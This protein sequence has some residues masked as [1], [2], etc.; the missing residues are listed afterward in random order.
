LSGVEGVVVHAKIVCQRFSNEELERIDLI[1]RDYEY[2]SGIHDFDL[3]NFSEAKPTDARSSLLN[4]GIKKSHSR[5]LAFLDYDDVIYPHSYALLIE[6][7]RKSSCAIAFSNNYFKD[8]VQGQDYAIVNNRRAVDKSALGLR[9]LFVDNFCPLHSF[10][11][12]R[13]TVAPE[14]LFF[15]NDMSRLEDYDFLLRFC[16]K[17]RSSFD[18][19]NEFTGDYYFKDDGSNSTLLESSSDKVKVALWREAKESLNKTR[20]ETYLSSEVMSQLGVG[21][22]SGVISILNLLER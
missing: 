19:M 1:I 21:V 4:K 22:E 18:C 5:Y 12:D 17:Y 10:V 20:G 3:L 14:D 16:A 15:K 2:I 8:V 6:N 7:L 13:S 11:I 9:D